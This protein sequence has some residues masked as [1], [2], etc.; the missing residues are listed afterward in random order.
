MEDVFVLWLEKKIWRRQ[1]CSNV[2]INT[3]KGDV[4]MYR[5]RTIVE[6]GMVEDDNTQ[7]ALERCIKN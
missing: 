4:E 7:I 1:Q 5:N 2:I 3:D 6:D